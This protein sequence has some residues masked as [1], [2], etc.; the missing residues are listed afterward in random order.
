MSWRI[1][2]LK[3]KIVVVVPVVELRKNITLRDV[4]KWRPHQRKAVERL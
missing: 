3:T 4:W 2:Q 1:I